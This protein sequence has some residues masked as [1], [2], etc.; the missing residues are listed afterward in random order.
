M[1]LKVALN[2][3]PVK[4]LKWVLPELANDWALYRS[5][6]SAIFNMFIIS[7]AQDDCQ[8]TTSQHP[9]TASGASWKGREG[10]P[11][12]TL[13]P[14][15]EEKKL[16]Q[17]LPNRFSLCLIGKNWIIASP[18]LHWQSQFPALLPQGSTLWGTSLMWGESPGRSWPW[19]VCSSSQ[20]SPELKLKWAV[21]ANN[22]RIS[23]FGVYL[24]GYKLS[25]QN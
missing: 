8:S 3:F 13:F 2:S 15:F 22:L 24:S 23:R 10:T 20:A 4:S 9:K 18:Q 14:F 6:C 7:W 5:P 17:K 16:S 1:K 11:P 19:L 12:H 25:S 21:S